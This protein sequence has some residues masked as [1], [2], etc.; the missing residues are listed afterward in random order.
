MAYSRDPNDSLNFDTGDAVAKTARTATGNSGWL[1]VG[2]AD[3]LVA[4]LHSDA[5][6]GTVP[7]LDVKMQTSFNGADATA[8]DVPTGAFTQVAGAAS[9]QVK[10]LTDFH[11]YVKIVWTIAGTTPSF[12][13]GVY[14]TGRIRR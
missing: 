12:D 13:F 1:D 9:N 11:R 3:E 14:V 4:Q 10:R 8:V 5:G 6:T 7:T 2:D